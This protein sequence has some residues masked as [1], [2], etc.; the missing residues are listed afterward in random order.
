MTSES[1]IETAMDGDTD[2]V[3]RETA[4]T[5]WWLARF[6]AVV[7]SLFL[8]ASCDTPEV[9]QVERIPLDILFGNPKRSQPRI[10]PDASQIAFLAP[11]KNV[12]NVWVGPVN[13][14]AYR[15]IT[16]DTLSGIR[17]F[18]WASDSRHLLFA[19]DRDGDEKWHLFAANVESG[20]VRNLTPFPGV[21]AELIGI[22]R[23]TPD[24][25][26]V[27]LNKEDESL[28]DA[29]RLNVAT[30]E[31][32]LLAENTGRIA[33]WVSDPNLFVRGAL[34]AE[35]RGSFDFLVRDNADD[36]WRTLITWNADEIM[37]SGVVAF[38]RD[39][40]SVAVLDSRASNTA[41]LVRVDLATGKSEVLASHPTF[42][43]SRAAVDP[44]T[45]E[46]V[47]AVLTAERDSIILLDSSLYPDLK[48]V[49]DL[50]RGAPFI[51][52]RD[53]KDS[54]WIIGFSIDDEPM[55]YYL[56]DRRTRSGKL[57]FRSQPELGKYE[58][59]EMEP[60]SF[61][62]RDSLRIHGYITFPP[63]EDRR[64]LPMVL[65]VHGGPWAR[66]YWGFDKEAQ[67]LANR[68]YICLQV[69]YR[70]SSGYGREFLSA[71]D[72]EWGAKMQ[73][74]LADAVDW[75]V[76]QGYA[77]PDQL[78]IFGFSYGGYAALCGATLTPDLYDCAVSIGG[79]TDLQ[80]MLLSFPARWS[81]TNELWYEKLGHPIEDADFLLARSPISHVDSVRI[82]LMII[83]GANDA[84]VSQ[85][86][87]DKFVGAVEQAEGEV[88]YVLLP[89]EGHYI[90]RPENR[91]KV[92]ALT[93]RFLLRHLRP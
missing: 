52:S 90:A 47:A 19:Q 15:P 30:G 10:A 46:P 77:H 18:V 69:N 33:S 93:E 3:D 60:I 13:G 82:P 49:R 5:R 84:R 35:E 54:I 91:I 25:V 64:R 81:V 72:G 21:N 88:Q 50:H 29:Y 65:N 59:A 34:R 14:S 9:R 76:R 66:D 8:F 87:I 40:Q 73:T 24:Y 38:S 48:A 2:Q 41:R 31:L 16:R 11:V 61:Y 78:G 56:Y 12:L 7:L 86:D 20:A 62:A 32:T 1:E 74:D 37:N 6:L 89:D 22:D 92:Y 79:P 85:K 45:H 44:E 51:S 83:H 68:G 27:S 55:P 26:L 4:G 80:S 17:S 57:L 43:I 36:S 23:N 53:V 75:A 71:G 42:D 70:G 58:L 28:N 67:W 39:G 63:G